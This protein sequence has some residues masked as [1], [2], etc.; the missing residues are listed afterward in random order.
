MK[1][2]CIVCGCSQHWLMGCK[3]HRAGKHKHEK[4]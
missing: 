2:K 1:K 3:D 4:E